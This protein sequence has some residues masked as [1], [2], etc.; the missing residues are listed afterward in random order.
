MLD[1]DTQT[2]YY[3]SALKWYVCKILHCSW[4]L[5][6]AAPIWTTV[7]WIQFGQCRVQNDHKILE[8]LRILCHSLLRDLHM[9][10]IHRILVQCQ[11]LPG[12]WSDPPAFQSSLLLQ[13]GVYLQGLLCTFVCLVHPCRDLLF[14]HYWTM[15][16]WKTVICNHLLQEMHTREHEQGSKANQ[17]SN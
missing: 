17:Q 10:H 13:S 11:T 5:V 3:S 16:H 12:R 15:Q 8:C 6:Y 7:P 14:C 9:A 4:T 2:S 1:Y